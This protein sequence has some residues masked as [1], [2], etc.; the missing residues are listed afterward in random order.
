MRNYKSKYQGSL[1]R[2]QGFTLVEVAIV[3]VLIMMSTAFAI[4]KLTHD[5]KLEVGKAQ[6]QQIKGMGEGL[7]NYG[8][9]NMAAIIAGTPVAGVANVNSPT[10][11]ELNTLGF[12]PV[13]NASGLNYY[14]TGFGFQ[15]SRFPATCSTSCNIAGIAYMT[16][17][18][19]DKIKASPTAIDADALGE[20]AKAIGADGGFALDTPALIEGLGGGWNV[21]NPMNMAGV[22][23]MR[24]GAG[25]ALDF[26][27]F[28]RHD[29]TVAMTGNFNVGGNNITNANNITAA[30]NITAQDFVG[31]NG[32]GRSLNRQIA[33]VGVMNPGGS[34]FKPTCAAGL[35][36]Q[37]FV[38]PT[39]YS[40]TS[41]GGSIQAVQTW[42]VDEGTTWSAHM[43]ILVQSGWVT[44]AGFTQGGVDYG[45]VQFITKCS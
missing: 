40:N 18:V 26:G 23:A 32:N 44:D 8:L 7:Y 16:G 39:M 27:A 14:G 38:T 5:L 37:I 12:M 9:A 10:F 17:P 2:N 20:A 36:P 1:K 31:A 25:S 41:T 42:A 34:I 28:V 6:G 22:L 13:Q 30:G 4:K 15:I 35:S 3:T 24:V 29:G 21:A 43:R 11:A 45:K 19:R 33:E